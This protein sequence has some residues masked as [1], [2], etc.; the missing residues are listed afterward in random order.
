MNTFEI[1]EYVKNFNCKVCSLDE[2][3]QEQCADGSIIYHSEPIA[4]NVKI[5]H[6]IFMAKKTEK[7]EPLIIH[8]DTLGLP[9][10]SFNAIEFINKNIGHGRFVCNKYQIQAEDS[11][12]CGKYCILLAYWIYK[13]RSFESFLQVFDSTPEENDKKVVG[14]FVLFKKELGP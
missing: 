6:W 11:A 8:C 2:I 10:V 7:G 4:S 1:E 12:H 9:P 14:E 5:G 3:P 13:N